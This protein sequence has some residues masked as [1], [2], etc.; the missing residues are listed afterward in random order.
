MN[1]SSFQGYLGYVADE[2]ALG[3]L[4]PKLDVYSLGVV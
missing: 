2:L 3:E 1:V 4:G